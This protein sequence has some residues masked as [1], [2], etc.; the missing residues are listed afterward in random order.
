VVVNLKELILGLIAIA[1]V[2]VLWRS[3]GLA[4]IYPAVTLWVDFIGGLAALLLPVIRCKSSSETK[5]PEPVGK[6]D[7]Q[8]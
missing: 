7:N 1:G 6:E 5:S 2:P 3:S 8:G 4:A